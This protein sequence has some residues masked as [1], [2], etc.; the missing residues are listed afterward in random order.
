MMFRDQRESERDH[1]LA[2]PD[3]DRLPVQTLADLVVRAFQSTGKPA[4]APSFEA[5]AGFN[6][7][8]K[9]TLIAAEERRT[10]RPDK[11]RLT[12]DRMLALGLL[13]A[14]RYPEQPAG[15][16]AVSEAY[17]NLHKNAY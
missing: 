5:E 6:L 12:V 11:A 14:A 7:T 15:Y 10:G 13:L 16:L 17:I 4:P 2:S 8:R 3:A 1:R 9:L